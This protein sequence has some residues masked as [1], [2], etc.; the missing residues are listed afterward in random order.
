VIVTAVETVTGAAFRVIGTSRRPAAM[1]TLE[2]TAITVGADEVRY[3]VIPPVGAGPVN[4]AVKVTLPPLATLVADVRRFASW[5]GIPVNGVVT[6]TPG[7]VAE[8][9]RGVFV[10]T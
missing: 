10:D 5:V 8:T 9:V 6:T 2:G 1:N 3:T 7:V 4:R